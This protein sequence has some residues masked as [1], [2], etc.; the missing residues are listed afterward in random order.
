MPENKKGPVAISTQA[1]KRMPYYLQYLQRLQA[2]GTEFVAAP[3]IAES[4]GLNEVQVR[5]DF[6]AVSTAKGKPKVGF[7]VSELIASMKTLLG[8]DNVDQA[9]L[10]GVGSLGTALL[11]YKG[12]QDY[13]I[14]IVAAFDTDERVFGSKIRGKKVFPSEMLSEICRRLGVHIGIIAVPAEQAQM[15]C[16]Q[17]VAGG[18]LAI[19]NFAPVHL[20]APKNILVQNENMA[21]SLA[22][23]SKHLQETFDRL[24]IAEGGEKQR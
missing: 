19:W 9:V 3:A 14:Q 24:V 13:G 6:A 21:A 4:L 23:L 18:V 5:K 22:L 15:A 16:D 7:R 17:L 1:L 12:F 8:H 11:S 2:Q 10:V 20:S